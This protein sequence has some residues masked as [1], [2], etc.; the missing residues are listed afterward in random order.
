MGKKLV[1]SGFQNQ[2]WGVWS[3]A[4]GTWDSDDVQRAILLDIRRE[5]RKINT[6]LECKNTLRIPQMLAEIAANT[7]RP[8]RK[9]KP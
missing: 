9:R 3:N 6:V 4:D 7:R 1:Y 5:L 2:N 8:R